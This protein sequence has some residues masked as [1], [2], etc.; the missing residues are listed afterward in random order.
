M[1]FLNKPVA[2]KLSTCVHD[3]Q[4]PVLLAAAQASLQSTSAQLIF[5]YLTTKGV[6]PRL[7]GT[8]TFS[9]VRY[10]TG[11]PPYPLPAALK[12]RPQR[13]QNSLL[14]AIARALLWNFGASIFPCSHWP[15]AQAGLNKVLKWSSCSKIFELLPYFFLARDKG[16]SLQFSY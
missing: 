4:Q 16:V 3:L 5:N 2:E 10:V 1:G 15:I 14:I 7:H 9:W 11:P 13:L 12:S 6:L 8:R